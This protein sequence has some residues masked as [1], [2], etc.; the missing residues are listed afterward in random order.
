MEIG[1]VVQRHK[2]ALLR[3]G[4]VEQLRKQN[5]VNRRDFVENAK[6]INQKLP[7]G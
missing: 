4:Y 1:V 2:L 7:R 6:I 5:L 3:D